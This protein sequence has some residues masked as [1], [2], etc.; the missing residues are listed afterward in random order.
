M[1]KQPSGLLLQIR[2]SDSRTYTPIY[3]V[4]VLDAISHPSNSKRLMKRS[5]MPL[6]SSQE[7]S[8]FS[9]VCFVTIIIMYLQAYMCL[10]DY[11]VC[12]YLSNPSKNFK[13]RQIST[14]GFEIPLARICFCEKYV[15]FYIS[16]LIIYM[17]FTFYFFQTGKWIKSHDF[18]PPP[19]FLS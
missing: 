9:I 11:I 10:Q 2:V 17:F 13:K 15:V 4:N 7:I 12:I 3:R 19:I 6:P 16:I 5:C 14:Y 18:M 8:S 1:S